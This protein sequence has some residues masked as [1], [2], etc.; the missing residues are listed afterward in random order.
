ML[1]ILKKIG[2]TESEATI[3]LLLNKR[4]P[5][6]GVAIAKETKIHRRTIYDNL[7]ILLNKGF[8]SNYKENETTQYVATNPTILKKREEEKI[9]EVEKI[10]P[11]LLVHHNNQKRMPLVRTVSGD[12][13]TKLTIIEMEQARS[14]ILWMG[15]G[16]KILESN[17]P[18]AQKISKILM[19]KQCRI[20]QPGNTKSKMYPIESTKLISKQYATGTA[21]FVYDSTVLIGTLTNDEFFI[22]KIQDENIAQTYKN[23]FNII[24][25]MKPHNV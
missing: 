18:I 21:F 4:G 14:E 17:E 13:A 15:G 3:Y 1:T 8:I 24:W 23:Y 20:I 5:M 11:K 10:L 6:T 16:F 19:G 7:N 25:Q 22:I 12:D 9:K 2:M